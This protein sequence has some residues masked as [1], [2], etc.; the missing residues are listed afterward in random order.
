MLVID[1]HI[2]WKLLAAAGLHLE[3][4]KSLIEIR[5][6]ELLESYY[7]KPGVVGDNHIRQVAFDALQKWGRAP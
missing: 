2:R 5:D 6:P 7:T 1:H 3:A 4:V